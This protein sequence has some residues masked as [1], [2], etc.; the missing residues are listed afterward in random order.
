MRD[1]WLSKLM[2]DLQQ[3]AA[4]EEF[5]ANREAVLARYPLKPEVRAAVDADDV[6][7]LAKLV[8]PYLIRFYFFAV[9]RNEAWFLERIRKTGPAAS[10]AANKEAAH[11]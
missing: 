5:K 1:Y 6:T 10:N 2:F 3:P 11:G 8:N 7:T 4:A 9:G